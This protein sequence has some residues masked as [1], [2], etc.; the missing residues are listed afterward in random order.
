M[1]RASSRGFGGILTKVQAARMAS[2]AGIS[3]VIAN[4]AEANVLAKIL[5][6]KETG[7]IFIPRGD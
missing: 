1:A 7:T 3:V 5:N 6:G 2:E 4:S